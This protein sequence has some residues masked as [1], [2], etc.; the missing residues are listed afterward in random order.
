MKARFEVFTEMS[1]NIQFLG[2]VTLW[3]WASSSQQHTVIY[4]IWIPKERK[5]F[6][7]MFCPLLSSWHFEDMSKK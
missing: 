3:D 4:Q 7:I 5:L 1:L 6:G 2:D